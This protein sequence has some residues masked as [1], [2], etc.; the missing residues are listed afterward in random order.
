MGTC[1]A[2]LCGAYNKRLLPMTDLK[3]QKRARGQKCCECVTMLLGNAFGIPPSSTLGPKAPERAEVI[4][5]D[6]IY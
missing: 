4:T 3:F 1:P 6:A 2:H 5:K